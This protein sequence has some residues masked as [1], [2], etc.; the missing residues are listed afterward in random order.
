MSP[1]ISSAAAATAS[2]LLELKNYVDDPAKAAQYRKAAV[3]M[4][5]SLA[6]A[7]YM[8]EKGENNYFLLKHSVASMPHNSSIDK[9]EIYADY[10]FLEA[11]LRLK[12]DR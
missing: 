7:E 4:L 6:S 1:L 12:N 2:A 5:K 10:Y 11:L 3:K 9:P 8:A